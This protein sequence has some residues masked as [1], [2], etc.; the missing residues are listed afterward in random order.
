[1]KITDAVKILEKSAGDN[2]YDVYIP[3]L[4][5]KIAF[6][7]ITVGM[8]KT[9]AKMA[10]DSDNENFFKTLTGLIKTLATEDI[11]LTKITELDRIII[12]SMI[13]KHNIIKPD[14]M[15]IK[16]PHCSREFNSNFDM[17]DYA[18]HISKLNRPT[19]VIDIMSPS[20]VKYTVKLGFPSTQ[21]TLNYREYVLALKSK[22]NSMTNDKKELEK[23]TSGMEYYLSKYHD[24]LY[25]T[26]ISINDDEIE[27]FENAS[28][29]ERDM[30][31]DNMDGAVQEELKSEIGKHFNDILM[32]LPKKIECLNP[33]CKHM[34]DVIPDIE[35]FFYS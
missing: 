29:E 27:D 24:F 10:I 21:T 32:E 4:N 33:E 8:Q 12:L 2:L 13:R 15:K 34:I 20:G 17:G 28:I 1:M 7:H 22:L 26:G 5:K 19:P 11:D 35:G 18:D 30:I 3:G 14:V 16:C 31:I 25:V 6:S 9:I 23:V